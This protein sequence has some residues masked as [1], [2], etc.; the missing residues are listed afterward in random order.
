MSNPT[1]WLSLLVPVYNVAAYLDECLDSIRRQIL[2][3]VEIVVLNDASTDDSA[4]I[5]TRFQ[6]HFGDALRVVT[7]DR[8]RG[9]A[10]A[11]NRMLREANG[12][13][14]WFVDGDDV[15]CPGAVQTLAGIVETDAPDL[16]MC[17]FR[18]LRQHFGLKHRLRGELH[19]STFVGPSRQ[20]DADRSTLVAGLLFHGQLH[21]WSKIAKREIWQSVL[22]PEGRYFEDLAV[23][24]QLIANVHSYRHVAQPWIA[25]RQREGSILADF[26]PDKLRHLALALRDLHA[27]LIGSGEALNAN[28]QF[29]VGHFCLKTHASMARRL[30]SG[31]LTDTADLAAVLRASVNEIF[32][33]GP[34]AILRGYLRRGW[35]L[36]AQRAR[37]SLRRVGFA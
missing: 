18:L 16:V 7:H 33:H 15:L 14:L 24:P 34:D 4:V 36:R 5:L 19:R 11:R 1:P 30:A 6:A 29:A 17:D 20:L 2:T 32:P 3:G 31:K 37:A 26:S 27:A 28:A 13:Y 35:L 9:V 10:A 21:C 22:F 23:M 25:Y 12:R 8:N